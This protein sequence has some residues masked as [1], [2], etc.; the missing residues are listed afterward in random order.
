MLNIGYAAYLD[1]FAFCRRTVLDASDLDIARMVAGIDLDLFRPDQELRRL[2]QLA[3]SLKV[4]DVIL[5]ESPVDV[6]AAMALTPRGQRWL[7]ELDASIEPWFNYSTGSGF[8]SDDDVWAE[9]LEVPLGFVR[10]YVERLR[11]GE[12]IDSPVER[13]VAERDAL[14]DTVRASLSGTDLQRFDEKV[15]LART[16]MRFVENHNFYVEHWGMSLVWRKAREFSRLFVTHGFWSDPDDM[17]MLRPDE[18]DQALRD[19][20]AGW[21]TGA[22]SR[23]PSVWPD[24]IRRRRDVL[25]A[26]A[27]SEPPLALGVPPVTVTEPFTVM[28]WG[29]TD[30][31]IDSWVHGS[32]AST[33]LHGCGASPGVVVGRARVVHGPADLDDLQEGEIM[34]A[35]LTSP[36]WGARL[37]HHR[38]HGRRVRRDDVS[39][40]HRL[41]RVRPSRRDR[42][43]RS[44]AHDP[45]RCPREDRRICRHGRGDRLMDQLS[46]V[47]KALQVMQAFSYEHPVL[48]VSE[49]SRRLGMGKSSVHRILCTLA[50]QGFVTKTEDDR[51]RLGL[52]LHELGQLVVSTLELRQVAHAPLEKLRNECGETVH[53]AVLEG[54]DAVYVH[55]FESQSTLRT[56]ARV[57]RR[58][59]AHTTSSGKC[60]LAFGDP[61]AIDVVVAAGLARIG[62]R[63]ITEEK[64]FREVLTKVRA[65]GFVVSV[66]ENERGVVSIG[67]P[68]FGHDGS[69]IAA[70]SMAGPMLRI[71]PEDSPRYVRMVR[72]VCPRHQHRHGIPRPHRARPRVGGTLTALV[73]SGEELQQQLVE[74]CRVLDLGPVAAAPEHV[75]L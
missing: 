41:S 38:R 58:V 57:G 37:R 34:V 1:Y 69:C 16:V 70:I 5:T 11:A 8:Y 75:Q 30:E 17:F 21:A 9:R 28:L 35:E 15:Q 61:A 24:E 56:F 65:D 22:P 7:A 42:R 46:T 23:G 71:T 13:I 32:I 3:I 20:L 72:P 12:C 73:R 64:R 45:H 63:S 40:R 19:L 33:V 27:A 54:A 47:T 31:S 48:G 53:V 68:V 18:V 43:A 67:A 49:L 66:E 29:I 36:S 55:R 60:L 10:T 52:R 2:A 6:L 25:D 44:D 39:R 62:P 4:D 14:T 51:Y 59:P 74:R 26:C 50:E